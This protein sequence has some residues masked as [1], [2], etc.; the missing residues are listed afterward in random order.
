LRDDLREVRERHRP[1][2]A[3]R[4]RWLRPNPEKVQRLG[5][6]FTSTV[7]WADDSKDRA[8]GDPIGLIPRV[9]DDHLPIYVFSKKR[10]CAPC[11]TSIPRP[12]PTSHATSCRVDRRAMHP[13][14]SIK[15][16]TVK[17]GETARNTSVSSV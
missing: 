16:S 5:L 6:P 3:E 2:S 4:E 8:S 1:T 12:F 9:P 17:A 13:A 15:A 11:R 10:G 14:P 7:K